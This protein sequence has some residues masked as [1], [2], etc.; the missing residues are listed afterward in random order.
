M[1]STFYSRNVR[2]ALNRK[3]LREVKG[4]D[5]ALRNNRVEPEPWLLGPI[6]TAS[7]EIL[8]RQISGACPRLQFSCS[9]VSNS[10]PPHGL[11]HTWFPCLSP[12]SEACS[13]SC[14]LSQWSHQTV[15]SSVVPF[16]CLQSFP[17]SGYFPSSQFFASGGQ[18]IGVSAS[19]SVLPM[20]IQDWFPLGWT[21]WISLHSKDSQE[22][23]PTPQLK[24]I[25]SSALS[26]LYSP[27]LTSIHD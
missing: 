23:S 4:S 3:E 8:L 12:A 24:T 15:S 21:D 20:H 17:A 19:A 7:C 26:F 22:P 13:N 25:N 1:L 16:S 5:K 6:A 18:S 27:T 10:L 11:Q 9:V 2:A 14:P